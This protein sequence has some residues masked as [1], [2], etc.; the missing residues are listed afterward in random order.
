VAESDSNIIGIL[1]NIS[2]KTRQL[3]MLDIMVEEYR[4]WDANKRQET[5]TLIEQ[6]RQTIEGRS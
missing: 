3:D 1:A 4:V 2:L 6:L 5:E